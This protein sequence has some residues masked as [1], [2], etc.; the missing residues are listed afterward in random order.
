MTDRTDLFNALLEDIERDL[1]KNAAWH[2]RHA[3]EVIAVGVEA[4]QISLIHGTEAADMAYLA[5][6]E[7]LHLADPDDGLPRGDQ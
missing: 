3:A 5:G 1:R 2:K 7:L 4:R 6:M